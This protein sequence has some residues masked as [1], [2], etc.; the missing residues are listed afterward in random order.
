MRAVQPCAGS[1]VHEVV[2]CSCYSST[3]HHAIVTRIAKW[4]CVNVA[5]DQIVVI[6]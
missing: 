6:C 3:L 5:A 1:L 4:R 2:I